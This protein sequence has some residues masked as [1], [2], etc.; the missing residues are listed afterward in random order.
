MPH[1]MEGAI[2]SA[3]RCASRRARA[4]RFCAIEDQY[5]SRPSPAQAPPEPQRPEARQRQQLERGAHVLGRVQ[6]G[7]PQQRLVA[8]VR[9]REH[10]QRG[11]GG[12]QPSGR[13]LGKACK[14]PPMAS[15]T[16]ERRPGAQ[17][18]APR[19]RD[20]PAGGAR[21]RA[22]DPP[23][24]GDRGRDPARQDHRQGHRLDRGHQA[25]HPQLALEVDGPRDAQGEL[26]AP[27][28]RARARAPG[29]STTRPWSR[30]PARAAV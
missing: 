16:A 25:Q 11:P 12:G 5:R 29:S 24:D 18:E 19:P 1:G 13:A 2:S 20:T 17:A 8:P 23:A 7:E 30:R 6:R 21:Q 3:A 26:A 9:G 27:P 22:Q 4:V 14:S 28:G 15:A 10:P